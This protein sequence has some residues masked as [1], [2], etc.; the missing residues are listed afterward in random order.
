MGKTP[1]PQK[2]HATTIMKNSQYY[3]LKRVK[4]PDTRD[5]QVR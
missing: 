4:A 2:K 1:L 5:K 3:P